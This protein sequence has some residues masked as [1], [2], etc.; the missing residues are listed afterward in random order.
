[1]D[2][3]AA[4]GVRIDSSISQR[5]NILIRVLTGTFSR[6]NSPILLIAALGGLI[7]P[8][9]LRATP[10]DAL[11]PTVA[12]APA[13]NIPVSQEFTAESSVTGRSTVKQ[14]N[15]SLGGVSSINSHF[16]YVVSPQINDGTLL[17]FGETSPRRLSKKALNDMSS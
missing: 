1:M 5:R 2:M 13:D 4:T 10:Q 6:C 3:N 15:A 17:R 7:A 12:P 14:G 16:N 11:T 9:A 8:G